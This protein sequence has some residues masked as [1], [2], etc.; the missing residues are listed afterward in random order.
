[1]DKDG[2]KAMTFTFGRH[3]SD[4]QYLFFYLRVLERQTPHPLK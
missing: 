2:V 4:R 3:L 1:M